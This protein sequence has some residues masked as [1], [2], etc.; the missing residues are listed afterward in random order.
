[1]KVINVK[2]VISGLCLILSSVNASAVQ[3]VLR[4]I[5]LDS[6]NIKDFMIYEKPLKKGS[7]SILSIE[8]LNKEG[9]SLSVS[10]QVKIDSPWADITSYNFSCPANS[11]NATNVVE[12][13][14]T[15]NCEFKR[16]FTINNMT[17]SDF[18]LS[19]V[20]D[21]LSATQSG[22]IQEIADGGVTINNNQSVY[23][24]NAEASSHSNSTVLN[25]GS[26]VRGALGQAGISDSFSSAKSS[27]NVNNNKLKSN[28]IGINTVKVCK[29]VIPVV[30]LQYRG[31]KIQNLTFDSIVKLI[32]C[33][34]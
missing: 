21:Y 19:Y 2:S 14:T 12:S 26:T 32:S 8:F 23:G 13:T 31:N 3:D 16:S 11:L 17:N 33:P 15:D 24:G 18:T 4:T 10:G 9:L 7:I 29:Q 1:M 27:T 25:N 28:N 22:E 6:K 30:R 20:N 34:K 5:I